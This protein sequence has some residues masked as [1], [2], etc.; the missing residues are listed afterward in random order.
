MARVKSNDADVRRVAFVTGAGVR[1]ARE[2]DFHSTTCI[3]PPP[4]RKFGLLREE[5]KRANMPRPRAPAAGRRR[6]PFR[7][8]DR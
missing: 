7:S 4:A 3:I 5:S 2:R 1:D 6:Y 8:A